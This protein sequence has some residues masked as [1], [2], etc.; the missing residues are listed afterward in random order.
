MSMARIIKGKRYNTASAVSV[1]EWRNYDIKET[2]LPNVLHYENLYRKKTGEYFLFYL[3]G[4]AS[5]ILPLSEEAA[6][7]WAKEKLSDYDYRAEFERVPLEES[8]SHLSFR[9]SHTEAEKLKQYALKHNKSQL[10]VI[11]DF[12]KTL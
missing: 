4:V 6:R 11:K 9:V 7:T 1:G 3:I 5:V 2:T 8:I 10:T 12:L